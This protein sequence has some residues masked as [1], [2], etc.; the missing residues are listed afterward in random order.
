RGKLVI[1]SESIEILR[2]SLDGCIGEFTIVHAEDAVRSWEHRELSSNDVI[3]A[4]RCL[5]R[6]PVSRGRRMPGSRVRFQAGCSDWHIFSSS[7]R[8]Y[9]QTRVARRNSYSRRYSLPLA[10]PFVVAED[11]GLVL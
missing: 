7:A 4:N 6:Q 10:Q 1:H 9:A 8:E 5:G 3:N 2:H 11:K